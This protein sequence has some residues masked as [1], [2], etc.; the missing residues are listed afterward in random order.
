F[1]RMRPSRLW[2]LTGT[3]VE[4]DAE[5]LATLLSLL[6]PK[7]FSPDDYRL[8]PG[9]LRSR[10]RQY[11]L[12]REK[13][14]VLSDLPPVLRRHEILDLSGEQR[15]AYRAA[16]RAGR[17]GNDW[18][19]ALFNELRMICDIA[20][21]SGASSKLDRIEELLEETRDRGEKAIVFS[22]T[23]EP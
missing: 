18:F 21:L 15:D 5:D 11:V 6:E 17:K 2:A 20:P 10:A 4:R 9:I 13:R 1:R 14:D 19:L 12:R 16:L 8:G 3:P 7:R 22:Y 23:L